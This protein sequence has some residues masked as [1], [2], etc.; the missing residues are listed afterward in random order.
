MA[1]M[2]P[3]ARLRE[4]EVHHVD[5]D[6]GYT[7]EDWSDAFALRLLREIVTGAKP[8]APAMVLRPFGSNTRSRSANPRRDADDRRPDPRDRGLAGRP[9]RRRG[10]DHLARRRAPDPHVDV[11]MAY[12]G[13]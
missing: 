10:S 4:V 9:R 7:P 6:A 13:T 12:T 3:W 1:A 11:M 2:L 8:D 5:L